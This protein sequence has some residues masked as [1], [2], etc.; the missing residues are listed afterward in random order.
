MMKLILILVAL[1]V[2]LSTV[3]AFSPSTGRFSRVILKNF[4][5]DGDNEMSTTPEESSA[6][7]FF[8]GNKRVRLGRSKDEDGKSNIWS[9]EPTM[10]VVEDEEGSGSKKNLFILGAVLG[11]VALALPAFSAF[12]TLLPDPSNY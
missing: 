1:L 11:A 3:S 5:A 4:A 8:D 9:I 2:A 10:Q 12:T 6:P 7:G